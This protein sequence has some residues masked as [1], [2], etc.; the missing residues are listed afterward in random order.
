MLSRSSSH[1]ESCSY[2]SSLHLISWDRAFHLSDEDIG[3]LLAHGNASLFHRGKH[4][5]T[6][7]GTVSIGKATDTDIFWHPKSHPLGCV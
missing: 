2:D 1:H 6:S 5:V 7:L 4:W 3:S